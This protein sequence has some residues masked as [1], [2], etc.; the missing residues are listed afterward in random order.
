MAPDE[1]QPI[2]EEIARHFYRPICSEQEID[3]IFNVRCLSDYLLKLRADTAVD[4]MRIFRVLRN[5][6]LRS[7]TGWTLSSAFED[8]QFSAFA[9]TL[10]EPART[11]CEKATAGFIFSNDPNGACAP[12]PFGDL[13]TVSNS[14]EYFLFFMNL[15]TYDYGIPV[16]DSVRIASLRIGIRTMLKTEALDFLMDPRGIIPPDLESAVWRSVRQQV[17]FVIGHEYAHMALKHLDK[18][19]GLDLPLFASMR[20]ESDDSPRRIYN[21]SEVQ[22]L[23]AD[24]WALTSPVLTDQARRGFAIAALQWLGHIEVFQQVSDQLFPR[25]PAKVRSHPEPLERIWKVFEGPGTAL[26]VPKD[27]VE[28]LVLHCH[29]AKQFLQEDV[30]VHTDTYEFYGSVYLAEPNSEWRGPELRDRVDYY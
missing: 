9:S 19:R 23:E 13:V 8:E 15:A 16:P 4:H 26:G 22:E 1:Q 25:S 11:M 2:P 10:P 28:A 12:T 18:H 6:Y 3:R 27:S 20:T 17:R 29:G 21:P 14:L 30:A 7:P 5:R 24:N